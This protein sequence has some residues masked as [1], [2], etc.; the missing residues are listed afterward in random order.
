MTQHNN[1]VPNF[2]IGVFIKIVSLVVD[3]LLPSGVNCCNQAVTLKTRA[4]HLRDNS[5]PLQHVPHSVFA[6]M[7][8]L[9]P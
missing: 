2:K 5:G 9:R 3:I 6:A 7:G 4:K 1:D 8:N